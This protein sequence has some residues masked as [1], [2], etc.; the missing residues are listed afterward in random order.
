MATFLV[1]ILT[2]L[3]VLAVI[4]LGMTAMI[5]CLDGSRRLGGIAGAMAIILFATGAAVVE[6]E[7]HDDKRLCLSGHQEWQRHGSLALVGKVI[8]PQTYTRKAWVC[9]TW[10]AE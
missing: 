1:V 2:T 7:S 5:Q 8:I 3:W 4:G 9:D 10:E 6:S